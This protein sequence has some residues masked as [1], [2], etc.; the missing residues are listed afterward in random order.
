MNS[1]IDLPN[2]KIGLSQQNFKNNFFE[3]L[4]R[5]SSKGYLSKIGN[6]FILGIIYLAGA[7]H[8][9]WLLN[10]G[11][12]EIRFIDWQMFYDFYA[13]IQKAMAEHTVPYFTPQFYKGTNQFLA[14]PATDLFPTV[15]LLNYMS[16]EEFFLTQCLILYSLG[17]LG[18]LW[19]KKKFQ[20]SLFAFIIFFL[21]FNL[22]GHIVS[23]LAIGHWLW[24]SYFLFPFFI[25]W[26]L[27]L[28]EGDVSLRHGTRLAWVLFGMLLL[29]GIH[30]F[31][32][33]LL[34]L[35]ILCLYRRQYFKPVL[36]GVGLSLVFS[37]Y[38]IFPAMINYTGYE[39]TFVA[40]FASIP[41]FLESMISIKNYTTIKGPVLGTINNLGWWEVDHFIG[42]LGLGVILYFGIYLRRIKQE[43][44]ETHDY[45][46]LDAPM[47]VMTVLCFSYIYGIFT[48]LPIPL[49]TVERLSSRFFII[50][51][52]LL[53]TLSCTGMQQWL[54]R[55]K[56]DGNMILLML[57][58]ILLEGFVLLSHSFTWQVKILQTKLAKVPF[59][60]P[61]SD[62]AKTVEGY[63][64]PTV[65][66]S[67]LISLIALVTFFAGALYFKIKRPALEKVGRV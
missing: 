50:P 67:Y 6:Y 62:W 64:V 40:G 10:Y 32:W 33:C 29:G 19:L 14:I 21:I 31:V 17:Y 43:G 66:I 23:H 8:W 7:F 12:I 58:G 56:P 9:A 24:I 45:R 36:T 16:V 11:K 65:Q 5:S 47:V 46:V 42:V 57:S 26:V 59:V 44:W 53:I 48:H 30:P 63:Y 3:F 54:N 20:W 18:S 34:F 38:R 35:G 4:F 52:L 13:V 1:P 55:W 41:E 37:A 25:V 28:A 15:F 61:V 51:L 27:R 39:N 22:N 60:D 49:I 2:E